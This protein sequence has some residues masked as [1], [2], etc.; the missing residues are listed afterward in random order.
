M[1]ILILAITGVLLLAYGNQSV[2]VNSRTGAEQLITDSQVNREALTKA[3]ELLEQEQS[4]ARKDFN[5]VNAATSTDGFFQESLSVKQTDFFTKEVTATVGWLAYPNRNLSVNL[6]AKITNFQNAVGGNTCNSSPSGDWSHPQIASSSL[7]SLIGDVSGTYTIS[8]LDAYQ[9]KLYVTAS[10]TATKTAPT[11]FIFNISSTTPSISLVPGGKLDNATSTKTGLNAIAVAGNYAYVANANAP[12][13]SSCSQGPSCAQLQVVDI[14]NPAAPFVA[15]NYKISDVTGVGGVG[16]SIFYRDG[17]VYLGLS[18]TGGG[19]EFNI[20]DVHKPLFLSAFSRVGKFAVGK[21][22]NAVFAK[23][24]YAYLAIA[25]NTG[26]ELKSLDI[27]NV[28]S[29]QPMGSFDGHD[30]GNVTYAHG[31][32]LYPVGDTLYFGRTLDNAADDFYFLDISNPATSTYSSLGSINLQDSGSDTSLDGLVVRSNLAFL[33][34]KKQLQIWDL[35]SSSSPSLL[36]ASALPA[37]GNPVEP[38]IDCESN[39]L[40]V[41]SND[42]SGNGYISIISPG[43]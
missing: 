39:Y 6:S 14:S 33:V 26:K 41:G 30:S 36:K 19:P 37:S 29:P 34:T 5:L 17:Y 27:S 1:V 3:Q 9:G 10:D 12:D 42:S 31:K 13:F 11:I 35:A 2:I 8:D 22:L 4:L 15:A 28:Y 25:T 40:Y 18:Q 23:G 21:Q 43:P 24:N 38:S 32:S 20:I 7:A 16:N